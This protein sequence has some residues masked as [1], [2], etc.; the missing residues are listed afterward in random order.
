VT[1]RGV[2]G[3]DIFRDDTDRRWFVSLLGDVV[4]RHGWTCHAFC[5]MPN[6]YHLVIEAPVE[7][8]ARGMQALNGKYAWRFNQRH[9]RRG[10]VFGERYRSLPIE[11]EEHL[12]AARAYV[13]ANPVRAGLCATVD[14]WP[15]SGC[16]ALASSRP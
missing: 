2:D 8:L 13:L 7:R 11:S 4:D 9:E 1:S 5:L 16:P 12:E 6:H 14:E 3:E 15:W 10:H